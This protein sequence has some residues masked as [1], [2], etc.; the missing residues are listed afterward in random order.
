MFQNFEQ[1]IEKSI[2]FSNTIR[3]LLVNNI[4]S[5]MNLYLKS[6]DE[7][8]NDRFSKLIV[9]SGLTDNR[10]DRTSGSIISLT[11]SS[12]SDFKDQSINNLNYIF[13][14]ST[15]LPFMI[16]KGYLN[17]GF[18]L[19]DEN[20]EF[21]KSY[22]YI[23]GL[24]D[25]KTINLK[26]EINL[27]DIRSEL[28]SQWARFRNITRFQPLMKIRN[29]FGETVAL[30]FAWCGTM[31]STLWIISLIGLTFFFYGLINSVNTA[32]D[33]KLMANA[34]AA[35]KFVDIFEFISFIFYEIFVF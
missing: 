30:Y 3:S 12:M 15:G 13:K 28:T 8:L 34:S 35:V 18:I 29:Y 1:N 2:G 24:I 33:V 32:E 21:E 11:D 7:R 23:S 5:N 19:H 31:I 6:N 14:V 27:E 17:D 25:K 20:F 16:S 9:E 4:L 22:E 10:V 26:K